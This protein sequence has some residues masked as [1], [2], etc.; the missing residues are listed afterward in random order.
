MSANAARPAV[1]VPCFIMRKNRRKKYSHDCRILT[2]M[3]VRAG[4]PNQIQKEA[5]G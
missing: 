5:W 3:K 4:T 1:L 2:D